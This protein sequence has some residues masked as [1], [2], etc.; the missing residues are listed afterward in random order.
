M[1]K[2]PVATYSVLVQCLPLAPDFSSLLE[3]TMGGGSDG[4]G[5]RTPAAAHVG[6][7]DW[8]PSPSSDLA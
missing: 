2:T 7:L 1:V 5:D 8:V 4:S 3:Q 6:E